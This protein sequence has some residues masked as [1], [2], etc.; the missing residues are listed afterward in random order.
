VCDITVIFSETFRN[1]ICPEDI[2]CDNILFNSVGGKD[3]EI[4]RMLASEPLKVEGE[5]DLDGK[6]YPTYAAQPIPH[7]WSWDTPQHQAELMS[8]TLVDL[9][10]GLSLTLPPI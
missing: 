8:F 6:K 1:S 5:I 9:G 10:Q 2:K 3:D 4:E 7:K